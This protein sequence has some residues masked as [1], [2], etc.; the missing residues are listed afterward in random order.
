LMPLVTG[1][2]DAKAGSSAAP[3][4]EVEIVESGRE[5]LVWARPQTGR[6]DSGI[7]SAISE[8]NRIPLFM[9]LVTAV[10]IVINERPAVA[11]AFALVEKGT[12]PLGVTSADHRER[13]RAG[14]GLFV[15][16]RG[17]N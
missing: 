7:A 13:G 17:P 3:P 1:W 12:S 2:K 11:L 4:A 16:P 14:R 10:N 6:S 5:L 15:G 8:S 9:S